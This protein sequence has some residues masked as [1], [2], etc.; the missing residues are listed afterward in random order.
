[1]AK[2]L[3]VD[4]DQELSAMLREYLE[5]EGFAVT[6]VHDGENGSRE[7]L[8]GRHD[9]AVLDVMMP[10][11]SGVE[12]LGRIRAQ[13]DMPVIMLTAKGD[14]VDRIV[15][16]EMGAD[17]YVP[18]PCTPREL[19]ARIRAVL[20]RFQAR[21]EGDDSLSQPILAGPLKLFP[22]L[23]TAEWKTLPLE[24]TSTEFNLLA[25]LARHAGKAVSKGELSEQGLGRPL[26][27]FDRSIDVHMSRIRHKL[28]QRADGQNWIQT[29][30]NQGYQLSRE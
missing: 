22:Q 3:L 5:Q 21:D 25:L 17:D 8:S 11:M 10:L 29:I 6:L 2:L 4:D 13:S 1:M 24:L 7:A 16:L 12:V 26:S 18:K 9:L 20:R 19:A 15:G 27:R 28:G 23:R 14:D 30:R